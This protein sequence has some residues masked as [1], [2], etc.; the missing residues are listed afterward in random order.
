MS[1][2]FSARTDSSKQGGKPLALDSSYRS[3]S[4]THKVIVYAHEQE[5]QNRILEEGGSVI[6][7]YGAFSLLNAQA[8][9]AS[10]ISSEVR[11][12]SGVRDDMNVIL[13][14]AGA[15]DTTEGESLQANRIAQ[16]EQSGERLYLVQMVGPVKQEWLDELQS[17]AEVLAYV[18]NNAY[19]VRADQSGIDKINSLKS[20][21]R[22]FIQYAGAFRPGYKVAPE[23]SLDSDQQITIT[24]QFAGADNDRLRDFASSVGAEEMVAPETVSNFTNIRIKV[25][26]DRLAEVAQRSDVVWIEPYHTPELFDERQGLILA[27]SFNGNQL[28]R[29]S[30]L[31]WLSSKGLTTAPDFLVDIADSGIDKGVLD[32]AVLHKDFLNTASV[33]RVLYARYVGAVPNDDPPNDI[34]GHGT[35]N[36]SIVGGYNTGTA[37]PYVDTLGYKFG[38]GIHPYVRMG[39][40]KIFAPDYTN[41]SYA[42]LIDTMYRDGARISSNSWGAYSNNYTVDAQAYDFLVR[43]ARQGVEGNQELTVLFASGNGGAVKLSSPGTAKNVITVGASENLRPGLDGCRIDNEG[44]DDALS[45]IGF[46]SGG[47]TNDGRTKPD[48]AAP[49]T[50]IQGAASQDPFY[51]GTG[52]CGPLNYPEGQTLY[53][54]SSGTSHSTPAVA[55][56]A[57]L[58]RQFFQN[59]TGHAPSPAMIKAFLTNSTTYMTG[60]LAGGSLPGV[61]QGWGLANVG[62]ALDDVPRMSVDQDQVLKDTGQ[63]VT[64]SGK[65]ADTT[66]PFRVTLAWTDAPGNPLGSPAVNNLDL[67]VDIGGKTYLGNRFIGSSSVEGGAADNLNNLEGVWLPEGLS[68]DFTVRV[69]AGN[70]AGD[71]V[72]G[73]SD[74]TD[75]DFALVVYNATTGNGGGGGGG[76]GGPIDPPPTVNLRYPVGGERMTVGNLVRILWDASD[77]K[78]IQSQRVDVSLDGGATY[79]TL[80]ILNGTVRSFDWKIPSVPTPFGRIKVTALDGVNLPVSAVSAS[81]FEIVNGPPDT[82]PPQVLLLSPNTDSVLGGGL[83][84]TIKWKESDNVGVIERVIEMSIDNGLTYQRIISLTAPS[85]GEDQ[86]YDWQVPAAL[87]TD[88]AKVR[89]TVYDGASNSAA[90]TSVGKFQ[91][92]QLPIITGAD[93]G[94]PSGKQGQLEVFGRNFRQ[95]ETEIYVDG[96]KLKK[97]KFN[98]KCDQPDGTCKKVSSE[99]KKINK[100]VPEGRFVDIV[101]K[102]KKTGQTSPSFSWKRKPKR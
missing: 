47:P 63:T 99:D 48:I 53:T 87:A 40:S 95:N 75:Q 11:A 80:G 93:Y 83:T 65:I 96:K 71:G 85:S 60:N 76:G 67:Q 58:V 72:P 78:E 42:T 2:Q 101:V 88:K 70:I 49:G 3:R 12:G 31:T 100:F 54:W 26:A 79:N 86:S 62:R 24:V 23:I 20:S 55:G 52:V 66:K 27:S 19:L 4:S 92:W 22:G 97:I 68:G 36:A 34:G 21:E 7:D 16:V 6:A 46:S 37:F 89:I 51:G 38:L 28:S 10:R 5:L 84:T 64:V 69:V 90:I 44:G 43:D 35:I 94:T 81:N 8:A 77:N 13:L 82:S 39:V 61:N 50:H 59:S 45:L 18:P 9:A 98:D 17:A 32:P 73:N 15:F 56:A 41:P 30:Y 29:T 14:R 57:A 25:R 1:G 91:I 74:T 102:L 33:A